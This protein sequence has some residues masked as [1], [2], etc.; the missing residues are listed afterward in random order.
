MGAAGAMPVRKV[1]FETTLVG[2]AKGGI[3]LR[4]GKGA[5]GCSGSVS[6]S[7]A[8]LLIQTVLGGRCATGGEGVI[9]G[10]LS[11]LGDEAAVHVGGSE[12]GRP[13]HLGSG[14]QMSNDSELCPR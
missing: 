11:G 2:A 6:D 13:A 5:T 12:Q 10:G 9:Q 8:G 14:D 4:P 3:P 7:E 1:S